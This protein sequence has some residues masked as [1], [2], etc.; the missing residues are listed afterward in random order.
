MAGAL[1]GEDQGC[2]S[3]P[4]VI[5]WFSRGTESVSGWHRV[6]LSLRAELPDGVTCHLF[7]LA[8]VVVQG[9]DGAALLNSSISPDVMGPSSSVLQGREV[10]LHGHHR[11]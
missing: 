10:V 6:P 2:G 5:S 8:L 9:A 1:A 4:V 11:P 7:L 3:S